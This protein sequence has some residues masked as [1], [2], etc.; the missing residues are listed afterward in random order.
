MPDNPPSLSTGTP[1][2]STGTNQTEIDTL[3]AEL[4]AEFSE[5]IVR[6]TEKF[7]RKI[8]EKETRVMEVLAVF[9]TLFTFISVNINIFKSAQN[10]HTAVW[11][12][13]LMAAISLLILS[14][15]FCLLHAKSDRKVITIL[16]SALMTFIVLLVLPLL[17]SKNL[18]LNSATEDSSTAPL[19][20]TY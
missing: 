6:Q 20:A 8:E 10:I 3:K 19:K 9:V 11:F 5:A 2:S 18:S 4:K 14:F 16:L 7:A 13:L 12:M 1:T 17:F 15:M